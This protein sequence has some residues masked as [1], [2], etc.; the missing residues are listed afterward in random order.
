MSAEVLRK[1]GQNGIVVVLR[2]DSPVGP[3]ELI[4]PRLSIFV[5]SRWDLMNLL[6][7]SLPVS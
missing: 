3:P 6:H 5:D 2:V 4:D 1:L 7:D